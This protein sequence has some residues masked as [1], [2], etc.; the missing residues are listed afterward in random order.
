M[1]RYNYV[2]NGETLKLQD[3]ENGTVIVLNKICSKCG[4]NL[5]LT[6]VIDGMTKCD[7]C[8]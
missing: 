6:E 8:N 7:N 5:R 3:D 2:L 4:E 1:K